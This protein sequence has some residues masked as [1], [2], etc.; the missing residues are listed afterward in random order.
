[1]ATLAQAR[2]K[3]K[4]LPDDPGI[5]IQAFEA[6]RSALRGGHPIALPALVLDE[7]ANIPVMIVAATE[8]PA[9]L[10]TPSQFNGGHRIVVPV[11]YERWLVRVPISEEHVVAS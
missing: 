2:S 1:M 9:E 6:D 7:Q 4:C 10:E 3:S 8:T 11:G 5:H